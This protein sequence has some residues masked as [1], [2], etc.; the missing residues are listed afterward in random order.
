MYN[1]LVDLNG[2]KRLYFFNTIHGICEITKSAEKTVLKNATDKFYVYKDANDIKIVA[3]NQK[4]QIIYMIC[5]NN[6]WKQYVISKIKE[7]IKVEKIMVATNGI[8]EN[9]FYSA[10]VNGE[11]VLVHCVLGNNAMPSVIAKLY[12]REFFL[13]NKCVYYSDENQIIGYQ[14]F[15]DSKPDRFVPCCEGESPYLIDKKIIYK[16]DKDIFINDEKICTDDNVKIPILVNDLLMWKSESNIHYS[17]LKTKKVGRFISSGIE[18]EIF[19]MATA[20]KCIYYYG[21]FINGKL[22]TFS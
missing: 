17:S 7:N 1:Y 11:M 9:L 8:N 19:A 20:D 14:S 13:Y 22:K 5:R 15:A 10:K 18:P 2:D 4:S 6:R 21:T 16:K 3:L 12:D